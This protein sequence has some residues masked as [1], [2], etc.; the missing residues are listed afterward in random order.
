MPYE[1]TTLNCTTV[2]AAALRLDWA[3]HYSTVQYYTRT[4]KQTKIDSEVGRVETNRVMANTF[5]HHLD[6]L[7]IY[8][9]VYIYIYIYIYISSVL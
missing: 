1:T 9:Y 8:I 7:I 5:H 3:G 6:D 4:P 2:A